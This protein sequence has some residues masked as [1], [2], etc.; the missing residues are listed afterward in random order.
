MEKFEDL[1]ELNATTGEVFVNPVVV[2]RGAMTDGRPI[3]SVRIRHLR[4]PE[5]EVSIECVVDCYCSV[6]YARSF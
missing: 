5:M 1:P 6:V 2:H 4:V 3:G